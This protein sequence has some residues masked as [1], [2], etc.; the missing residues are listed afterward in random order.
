MKKTLLVLS[1]CFLLAL[2]ASAAEA[3][4]IA[5]IDLRKVFD[6]Y[7]KTKQ[8]DAKLKEDAGELEKDRKIMVDQFQ[9]NEEKYNKP[10]EATKDLAISP[11]ERDKRKKDAENE[12]L[13]LRDLEGR[14]KQFDNT[15]RAQLAE[16]QRRIRDNILTEIRE[17]VKLK[18][19]TAGYTMVLDTAAET[20]NGTP[21]L[22]YTSGSDDL[23]DAVL[24]ELNINAPATPTPAPTAK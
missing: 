23:S 16:K 12:L 19:K 15:S 17:M 20:P 3:Q 21:I 18:V 22:L 11:A 5:T 2:G 14:I 6:G 4:K 9:K 10:M 8:A 24:K 7:W 1:S 13:G